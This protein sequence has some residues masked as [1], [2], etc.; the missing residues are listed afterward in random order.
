M[1]ALLVVPFHELLQDFPIH[2]GHL[3]YI[4]FY[5]GRTIAILMM[6]NN[7]NIAI[8][9]CCY[10]GG[11]DEVIMEMN[12]AFTTHKG[13]N[14]FMATLKSHNKRCASSTTM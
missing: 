14:C 3:I 2:V 13:I 4:I 12:W 11:D 8:I 10:W 9:S 6:V 5:Q 1:Q 7:V